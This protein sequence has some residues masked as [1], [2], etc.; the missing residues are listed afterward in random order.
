MAL[1]RIGLALLLAAAFPPPPAVAADAPPPPA[2][3]A[4]EPN[5]WHGT[6]DVVDG[7][8]LE[9]PYAVVD[10]TLAGPPIAGTLIGLLGGTARAFERVFSGLGE[11]SAAFDPWETKRRWPPSRL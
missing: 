2:S 7:L 4:E 11:M 9:L 3:Q 5:F 6:R 1:R 10:G 8:L